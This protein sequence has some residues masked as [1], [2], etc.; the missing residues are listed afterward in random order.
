MT[1]C[2]ALH[3]LRHPIRWIRWRIALHREG[4]YCPDFDEFPPASGR[5]GATDMESSG[6][7]G[8]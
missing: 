6:H 2:K 4:P 1:R 7:D 5:P 3:R 8:T